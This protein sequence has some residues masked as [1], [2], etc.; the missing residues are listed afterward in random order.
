MGTG[1]VE[2]LALKWLGRL[3]TAPVPFFKRVLRWSA[4]LCWCGAATSLCGCAPSGPP[5][6]EVTGAVTVDGEGLGQGY[7]AFDPADGKGD[8]YSGEVIAGQFSLTIEDGPKVVSIR[9][10]RP[11]DR[12]GPG[13]SE[14]F[15]QYLPP[16]YNMQS[17]LAADVKADGANTFHFDLKSK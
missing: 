1:S 10:Y 5:L 8:A 11:S 7:I 4:I 14:N 15:D 16:R 13:G 6:Y 9:A 3:P 2:I 12:P 17:E